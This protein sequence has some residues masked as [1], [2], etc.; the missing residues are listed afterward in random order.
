MPTIRMRRLRQVTPLATVVALAALGLIG[1]AVPGAS[2]AVRTAAGGAARADG[3]TA[4]SAVAAA[5]RPARV[6]PVATCSQLAADDFSNVPDAP[7]YIFSATQSKQGGIAFCTVSGYI[8][9]QNGFLLTLP[10][11][12]YTGQYVQQGCGGLCGLPISGPSV[13]ASGCPVA[14]SHLL[15]GEGEP[16]TAFDNQGHIGGEQDALWASNDPALRLSFGYTS[17]HALAQ[18]A[19]AIISAYYGKPPAYSFYEGCSGGGREALA[20]AQRY[21]HD[22]NG[23]LAGAPGNIETQLLSVWPAWL[24]DVNTGPHGREIL[25]SE[26][27]PALHAAVIK[28]CGNAKGLIEDPRSCGFDPASIECPAGVDNHSCLTPAQVT[29]ARDIYLGP[30]DGHGH[31]LYPGGEPYGSELAWTPE[32]IDP[33][34]DTHWPFDTPGYQIGDNYLKYMAYWHNPPASFQLKDVRFTRA[35]YRKLLPLAGLYNATDP[36]LAAFARDGGKLILYQGWADQEIPPFGTIGYYKAVVQDAGGFAASQ[37]FSRLYLVPNQYHCLSDGSP[38][39]RGNLL[40]PLMNWVEHGIAPGKVP[41]PLVHPTSTLKVITVHPVNPL[42]PPQGG[43]RGLNTRA[44]WIGRFQPGT[45]LW[46][47]T[48]GKDLVCRHHRPRD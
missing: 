30:S 41:F 24:I 2:G 31:W 29:V 1:A 16:A 20:E 37:G 7:T 4:A 10:V 25:T 9:P 19:K 47:A 5:P 43:A 12:T 35:F 28:A 33:S 13:S 48:V 27:L 45:E 22:F 42:I 32:F 8:A 11:S 15:A 46:C 38:A 36:D 17:E 40:G 18:A 34:T 39:V 44:R 14:A 23:I 3:R 6:K 26:K 21:P